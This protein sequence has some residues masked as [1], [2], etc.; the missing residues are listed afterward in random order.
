MKRILVFS[1]SNLQRDPRVRRQIWAL[2]QQYHVVAAGFHSPEM[3]GV[4]FIETPYLNKPRAFLDKIQRGLSLVCLRQYE[5]YY[6]TIDMHREAYER[7]KAVQCD[8]ILANDLD[9]LP[10]AVR[11]A[12]EQ[13]VPLL[14]DAHEYFPREFDN[15]WYWRWVYQPYREYLCHQYIPRVDRMMTVC[16]GI[17]QEYHKNFGKMPDVLVNSA[18]FH[19]LSVSDLEGQR[20]RMIHHGGTIPSRKLEKM[21][22]LMA[23]L[24]ER[25]TLDFMLVVTQGDYFEYLKQLAAHESR[26]RFL[27][28]VP[29]EQ[30]IP[31]SNAYDLGLYLLPP[32]NFNNRYALPNKL[33]EFIQS[34]LAVAIGPSPE[35]AAIVREWDCGVV[36]EDFE[37]RSMARQLLQLTPE[38]LYH[39][40]QQSA[41]A[42]Q[43]LAF[44]RVECRLLNLVEQ[45]LVAEEAA[46]D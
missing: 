15:L 10:L 6:W 11:L 17:A 38:R 16:Q 26:I 12:Q 31:F 35:M 42:A 39:Y 9:T 29:G 46:R 37:P 5:Q 21:V 24:D 33:F 23:Y 41:A 4:D 19:D 22:E 40:K 30:I 2:R 43:A 36:A 45:L 32:T 1:F 25:F 13:S 28:P 18:K 20:I 27:S 7:L 8:L 44:E 34:R 3:E 14:F